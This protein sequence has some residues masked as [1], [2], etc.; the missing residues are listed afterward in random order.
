[1]HK[2]MMWFTTSN[3]TTAKVR[4]RTCSCNM[5]FLQTINTKSIAHDDVCFTVTWVL[6]SWLK[7][8][9]INA[10]VLSKFVVFTS[11][12]R[13]LTTLTK[14][15]N[16]GFC[17]DSKSF[18]A[19][20]VHRDLIYMGSFLASSLRTYIWFKWPAIRYQLNFFELFQDVL[21]IVKEKGHPHSLGLVNSII[22]SYVLLLLHVVFQNSRTMT[23]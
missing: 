5:S 1:M 9:V 11:L 12:A 18:P 20:S 17:A 7:S 19:S 10:H 6:T 3:F 21:Q 16:R 22:S 14:C 4:F 2:G 23:P 13:S 15:S 8:W